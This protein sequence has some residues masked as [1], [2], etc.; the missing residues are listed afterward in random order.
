M[1]ISDSFNP[2]GHP[3]PPFFRQVAPKRVVPLKEI[4]ERL[5]VLLWELH[6]LNR[7][8]SHSHV[9]PTPPLD[10]LCDVQIQPR[11]DAKLSVEDYTLLLP[12]I[13]IAL[14]LIHSCP[15]RILDLLLFLALLTTTL[16]LLRNGRSIKLRHRNVQCGFG[17]VVGNHD[18]GTRKGRRSSLDRFNSGVGFLLLVSLLSLLPG[19]L[20][21]GRQRVVSSLCL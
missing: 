5:S 4:L 21:R 20:T 19:F 8:R 1:K 14:K 13:T 7:E 15:H 10:A 18:F 9:L 16:H 6:G 17:D 12:Q 3:G 2:G 11:L